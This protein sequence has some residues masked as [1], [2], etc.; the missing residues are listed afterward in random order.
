[1]TW[2][3]NEGKKPL[4][5]LLFLFLLASLIILTETGAIPPNSHQEEAWEITL[6]LLAAG[7]YPGS[8][9]ILLKISPDEL[10]PSRLG[11]LDFLRGYSLYR[12][13]RWE[14]A[15]PHLQKAVS[16]LP[17]LAEYAIFFMAE[18]HRRAGDPIGAVQALNS[19]TTKYP[20]SILSKE[21]LFQQAQDLSALKDWEQAEKALRTF[22]HLYPRSTRRAEAELLLG[23]TLLELG[24][25]EE[26]EVELRRLFLERP[27]TREAERAKAYLARFPSPRPITPQEV[28]RRAVALY[29]AG[30]YEKAVTE[31]NPFLE[32]DSSIPFRLL[33]GRCYFQLRNYREAIRTL[34]TLTSAPSPIREE[35]HYWMARSWERLGQRERAKALYKTLASAPKSPWADDALFFLALN[36]EDEKDWSSA[37]KTYQRLLKG[38]P[39]SPF[40]EEAAWRRAWIYYKLKDYRGSYQELR[41]FLTHNP[42]SALRSQVLYWQGRVLEAWGKRGKASQVYR[43]LLG[44]SHD[45]YYLLEARERLAGLGRRLGQRTIA[46]RLP[47]PEP[48]FSN[49]LAVPPPKNYPHLE[50]ARILARLELKGEAGEEYWA[51]AREY[52]EDK[53][54]LDEASRFFLKA[55][56]Y[57]RTL[58]LAKRYLRPL[59]FQSPSSLPLPRYWEYLYP[60]GYY[61]IAANQATQYSLDP[62]LILALIREESAFSKTAVSRAGARGLMQVLPHTANLV[63]KGMPASHR[64]KNDLDHPEANMALGTAYLAQMLQ[65]F[66]GNLTL[67]LAA[68]NA[69]PHNVRHWL[70]ERPFA[71]D[72]GFIEDIPFPETKGYVKR[73]LASYYRYRSLYGERERRAQ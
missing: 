63:A 31:L 28:Y 47:N 70:E 12:Q 25:Q 1:M 11:E 22:L 33:A 3:S 8:S 40:R 57:E 42:Q 43:E 27:E 34:E 20:D 13:G 32:K 44:T 10:P 6:K 15:L 7:D 67:A 29:E 4:P 65:E 19:L 52:P 50:K 69:G 35:T 38:Y 56:R 51:L 68:Y 66:Q 23:I 54:L 14:E 21:G 18:A 24:R 39:E 55:Q 61:E 37:L 59:Y 53:G 49:S 2:N 30:R 48:A 36:Y 58:W 60:L 26:A 45:D 16:S 71:E 72:V 41:A 9:A 64:P 5:L 62:Y 73:V 17:I 46:A